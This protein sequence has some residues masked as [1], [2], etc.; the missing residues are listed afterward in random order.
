[1]PSVIVAAILVGLLVPVPV[2]AYGGPGSI[3]SG[4]G[5]FLAALA[6]L[7]A[8]ALG[9]VWFPLKRLYRKVFGRGARAQE[10]GGEGA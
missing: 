8:A 4:I 6:T 9:F 3:V 7:M 1:M 10:E 2:F 5:A